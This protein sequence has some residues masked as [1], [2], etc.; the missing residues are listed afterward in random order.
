MRLVLVLTIDLDRLSS[1][2]NTG[3]RF[4]VKQRS[5]LRGIRPIFDYLTQRREG[6]KKAAE[7]TTSKKRIVTLC[8]FLGFS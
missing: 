8:V 4:E 5:K 3:C 6:E 7:K 1:R 2:L